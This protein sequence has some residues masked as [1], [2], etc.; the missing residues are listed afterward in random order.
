VAK[1]D[2]DL[3]IVFESPVTGNACHVVSECFSRGGTSYVY[4][5]DLDMGMVHSLPVE[6]VIEA[7]E[8]GKVH[9]N[10]EQSDWWFSWIQDALDKPQVF[11]LYEKLEEEGFFD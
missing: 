3:N 6:E 7:Q 8:H 2:V 10:V 4:V 9:R 1:G 11:S 5:N